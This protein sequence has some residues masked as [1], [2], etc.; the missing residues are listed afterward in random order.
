MP[1][2]TNRVIPNIITQLPFINCTKL[3]KKSLYGYL[4]FFLII[5]IIKIEAVSVQWSCLS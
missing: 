2:V 4:P 3:L 5:C 1:S